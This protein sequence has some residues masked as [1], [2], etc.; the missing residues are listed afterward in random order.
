MFKCQQPR[1]K[2]SGL[3]YFH[4]NRRLVKNGQLIVRSAVAQV[5]QSQF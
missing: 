3:F 5:V 1:G 4:L 2:P